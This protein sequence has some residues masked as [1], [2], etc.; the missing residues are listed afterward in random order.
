MKDEREMFGALLVETSAEVCAPDGRY[1]VVDSAQDRVENMVA[2]S[3]GMSGPGLRGALVL[4]AHAGF[5]EATYPLRNGAQ[6]DEEALVDWAGEMA[7]LILG[8]LRNR[9]AAQGIDF[10]LSTPTVVRGLHLRV[11]RRDEPMIVV[12]RLR[13]GDERV[14]VHCE[15]RRD[16]GVGL[17]APNSAPSTA[18]AVGET[19]LF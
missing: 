5:F 8:G 1:E 17:L 6:R 12:R 9:L 10:N 14:T 18:S 11:S 7:N 19:L 13:I 15:L 16:G 4:M 2:A 3:I